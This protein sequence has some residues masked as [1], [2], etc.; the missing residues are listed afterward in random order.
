M[1]WVY[2]LIPVIIIGGI[3]VYFEKKSGM[4]PP[5]K[6]REKQIDKIAENKRN[7]ENHHNGTFQ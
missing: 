5:T 3:A 6:V 2:L 7:H 1:I 4:K